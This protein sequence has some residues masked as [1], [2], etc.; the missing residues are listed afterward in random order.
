MDK[1][2]LVGLSLNNMI[3]FDQKS[4]ET[5]EFSGKMYIYSLPALMNR[6]FLG[7]NGR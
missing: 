7:R 2:I 3:L 4:I 6:V 1:S 5:L